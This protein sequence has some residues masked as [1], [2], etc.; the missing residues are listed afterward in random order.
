MAT[1]LLFWINATAQLEGVGTYYGDFTGI[2]GACGV[3]QSLLETSNYIALNVFDSPKNYTMYPRPVSGGNLQYLGEFNNGLNCGRWIQVTIGPNCIGTNDGAQNQAFCRGAGAKWVD[4]KYSGATLYVLVADACADANAWCRDSPYHLD[5]H[6]PTL[7]LFEKN[8]Q[9]VKDMDPASWNNRKITWEYVPAPDYEGDI[10]VYFMQG[11]EQYW[12]AIM[13]NN[14]PNGIHGIEQKVGNSWVKATM[15]SDMGQAYILPSAT[16]TPYRI[17]ITDADDMLLN[18][19]REYIFNRPSAC[20]AKCTAPATITTYTTY[21]PVVTGFEE[22]AI[23]D[24]IKYS[25]EDGFLVVHQNKQG[26]VQGEYSLYDLNGKSL[27]SKEVNPA[28]QV[29]VLG[30]LRSGAY[31][32][33]F[34]SLE[35]KAVV[36]KILY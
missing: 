33:S 2:Y 15:N 36:K 5:I 29:L 7:N 28:H 22:A 19:G 35:G 12:A 9:P 21:D 25:I 30:A 6:R 26:W 34:K 24:G 18:E 31:L 13:V 14:L 8:G 11:A 20:G 10:K 23:E 16:T 4:D 3:P 27:V 17:R 32:L 1:N